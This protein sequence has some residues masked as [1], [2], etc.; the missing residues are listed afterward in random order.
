MSNVL[1]PLINNNVDEM[2]LYHWMQVDMYLINSL[3]VPINHIS[4]APGLQIN[5]AIFSIALTVDAE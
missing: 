3:I 4:S 2:T 5:T 1:G